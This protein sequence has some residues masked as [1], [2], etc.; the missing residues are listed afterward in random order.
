MK[1]SF[2]IPSINRPTLYKTI[3]SINPE[4]GDE[5]IVEF[6]LPKSGG[7]GN[8]QRNKGI[9]RAKGDYLAFIDDDDEYVQGARELMEKAIE[10]NPGKAIL[11]RIVYP[12]GRLIWEEK[13]TKPGNVSTQMILMP[14]KPEF[15]SEWERGR[16]MADQ[17]FIN[18]WPKDKIVF[19]QEIIAFLGN[20][21]K[22]IPH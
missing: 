11:F 10:D 2:I 3:A 14:N 21:G 15:I 20:D 9:P 6:D 22:G 16:N 7:W 17:I 18:K 4:E 8:E 12:D 1:I 13:N 5:V 19:R